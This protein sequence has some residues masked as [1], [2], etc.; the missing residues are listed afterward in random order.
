MKLKKRYGI[1]DIAL[2]VEKSLAKGLVK[3]AIR[4]AKKKG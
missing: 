3:L 1:E 4:S 2:S